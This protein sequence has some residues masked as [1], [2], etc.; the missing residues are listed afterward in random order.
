MIDGMRE[1][2][3][4]GPDDIPPVLL[5]MLREEVATPL[6]VLFQKLIDVG[7]IPDEWRKANVV[8][9]HK[10][11]SRT[12]PGNYRPVS[13]RSV[14]GK[15]LER[16]DKN[17]IDAYIE[18]NNLIEDSQ[19]GFRRGRSTQTNLIEFLNVTTEWHDEGKCYDVFYLDFSK[20]FDVVCHERLLIKL[21][22]LGIKE[23]VLKWIKDWISGRNQRVLIDG[24]YSEWVKVVSSVIQGSILGGIFFNIFIGDIDD[25]I[26]EALIKRICRRHKAGHDHLKY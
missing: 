8:P 26:L 23:K 24:N 10:K 9:I 1:N 22:A 12:E 17:E 18:N 5:K 25:A 15:L 2:A 13:L 21:E 19:H 6:A 20:A 3:A 4:A 16:I 11:V 7:Q 14:T